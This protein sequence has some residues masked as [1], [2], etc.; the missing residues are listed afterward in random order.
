MLIR[1]PVQGRSARERVFADIKSKLFPATIEQARRALTSG[2]LGRAKDALIRDVFVGIMK[3][4]VLE[5]RPDD[6]RERQLAALVAVSQMYPEHARVSL[7]QKLPELVAR[8]NETAFPRVLA[9]LGALEQAW[10]YL[11]ET[12]REA[13]RRFIDTL[14]NDDD[15][16][17]STA[18]IAALNIDQLRDAAIA[19]TLAL[20][21]EP[22]V[23][24]VE[25]YPAEALIANACVRLE[26]TRS[27]NDI[28]DLRFCLVPLSSTMTTP[29]Y[30][31][32][33]AALANNRSIKNYMGWG[34][35]V[36]DLLSAS[37]TR[38][39]DAV[40]QWVAVHAMAS[41][42]DKKRIALAFPGVLPED[43]DDEENARD[44]KEGAQ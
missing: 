12:N 17:T 44:E 9:L 4:L 19:R 10:R 14:T 27:F 34:G 36:R 13:A 35:F 16:A 11:N 28:R 6:E 32:V 29:S 1:P 21:V 15:N 3:D 41:G 30:R 33:V 25:G 23:A 20:P 24:V 40:D 37:A 39:H 26:E 22:F 2:P 42:S 8:V 5:S 31:R 18:L 38:A 43:E 7:E